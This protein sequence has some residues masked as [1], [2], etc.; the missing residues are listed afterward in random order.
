MGDD[1]KLLAQFKELHDL[2]EQG[3]YTHREIVS[4]SMELL[5]EGN[6]ALWQSL[7]ENIRTEIEAIALPFTEDDEIVSFGAKSSEVVKQELLG[8][9][10]WLVNMKVQS[11]ALG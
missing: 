6:T 5:G 7:P 9:K 4:K 10:R 2:Y 8:L 1:Q 3:L 11:Q